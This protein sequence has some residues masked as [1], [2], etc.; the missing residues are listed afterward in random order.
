MK[1][2]QSL[3]PN[4]HKKGKNNA[5]GSPLHAQLQPHNSYSHDEYLTPV[6]L[7]L[8][9][10]KNKSKKENKPKKDEEKLEEK[11]TKRK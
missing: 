1:L 4:A 2:K 5:T 8:A 3:S 9:K 6:N 10:E 11:K 7:K